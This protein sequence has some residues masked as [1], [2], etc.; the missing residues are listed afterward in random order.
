[1]SSRASI[2]W[3]RSLGGTSSRLHTCISEVKP[4]LLVGRGSL[5][6][7]TLVPLRWE[8]IGMQKQQWRATALVSPQLEIAVYPLGVGIVPAGQGTLS[9]LVP[10]AGG[11]HAAVGLH[12]QPVSRLGRVMF[13]ASRRRACFCYKARRFDRTSCLVKTQQTRHTLHARR[14]TNQRER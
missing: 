11:N 4:W 9:Q 5:P 12:P 7:C 10:S 3:P 1:M 14:D 8:L 2:M 13:P 6:P